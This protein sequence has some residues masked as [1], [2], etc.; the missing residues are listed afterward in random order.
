[1]L[2]LGWEKSG[3]LIKVKAPL[4]QV[5]APRVTKT[6]FILLNYAVSREVYL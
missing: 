2:G 6:H 3:S 5:Y 1:M 4:Q